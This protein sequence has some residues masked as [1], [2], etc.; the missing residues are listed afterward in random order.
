MAAPCRIQTLFTLLLPGFARTAWIKRL[1]SHIFHP[2]N[3]C[4]TPTFCN[5]FVTA[6]F[7][8]AVTTQN[9]KCC[10]IIWR[11]KLRSTSHAGYWTKTNHI[12]SWSKPHHRLGFDVLGPP[13]TLFNPKLQ[14]NRSEIEG[15]RLIFLCLGKTENCPNSGNGADFRENHATSK[16]R[17][18]PSRAVYSHSGIY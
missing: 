9:V 11:K 12:R 2:T 13:S 16:R 4:V 3:H 17:L 10:A 7:P 6:I 18:A 1:E 8:T 15:A 5:T 14:V